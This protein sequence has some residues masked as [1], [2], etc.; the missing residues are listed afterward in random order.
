ML[1]LRMQACCALARILGM[2][3]NSAHYRS[4]VRTS[5]ASL[6]HFSRTK[7]ALPHP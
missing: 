2:L 4:L 1:N 7:C 3:P 6:P 5:C